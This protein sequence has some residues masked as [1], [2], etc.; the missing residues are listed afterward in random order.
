MAP[1]VIERAVIISSGDTL[2]VELPQVNKASP[3]RI[4]TLKEAERHHILKI[5]KT[6]RWR[7]KGPRGAAE[8]LGLKPSTLYSAM[9]RLGIAAKRE[10]DDISI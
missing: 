10:R 4:E 1:T 3:Y 9:S 5:L 7:I 8:L 2:I 6:T